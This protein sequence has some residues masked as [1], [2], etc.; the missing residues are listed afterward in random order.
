MGGLW[1][2]RFAASEVMGYNLK[3]G[4]E[5][6]LSHGILKGKGTDSFFFSFLLAG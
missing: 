4:V 1:G 6:C 3:V 5:P 2:E